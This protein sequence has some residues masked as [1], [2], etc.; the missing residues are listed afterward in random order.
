MSDNSKN[1]FTSSTSIVPQLWFDIPDYESFASQSS[2][3]QCD[4]D[5]ACPGSIDA[6]YYRAQQFQRLLQEIDSGT[7]T[8]IWLNDEVFSRRF[9]EHVVTLSSDGFPIV[10]L[11]HEANRLCSYL[12]E[13]S[14]FRDLR[15]KF[16]TW[17]DF[18]YERTVAFLLSA[19]ILC[20][21]KMPEA[22]IS[23]DQSKTLAVWLHLTSQCNLTCKYCYVT[24]NDQRMD[25]SIAKRSVGAIFR[26]A[27]ANDFR[28]VKLKYGGGEPT[29]NFEAL[30]VA[31]HQ[32]EILSNQ[33]GVELESVLLTNGVFLT[34]NQL[35]TLLNHNVRVTVSLDG[36]GHN[37]DG[38]RPV[39]GRSRDSFEQVSHTLDRLLVR[40]LL[41]HI[42]VTITKENIQGL[43][44]LVEYLLNRQL[45]FSFNFYRESDH[46]NG[47][48]P[49]AFSSGQIIDGLRLTFRAIEK[50]L[51]SYSLLS[52]LANRADMRIPHL[53]TCG[54][55]HNYMVIDCCGK[56]AKCQM[57]MHN[58]VT[59]ISANDPLGV[60][61]TDTSQIQ[62]PLVDEKECRA[63]IWR[64][65][66]LGDCPRLTF[67]RTG[68]YDA[69]SPFCQVYQ[70]ILPEIVNLEAM[71][72]LKYKES[73]D[74]LSFSNRRQ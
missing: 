8:D 26:S 9:A 19:G 67:Q 54:V 42:S 14:T 4:C 47:P 29:L 32:A 25:L 5:G 73:W 57:D 46:L 7:V 27:L 43:P 60:V 44:R 35:D 64:Y 10:V 40:G 55:G 34:D 21:S 38:Q 37:Q 59:T 36:V 50:R 22:R 69:K 31:Q 65:H 70:T 15:V 51:P 74:F 18:E 12:N 6:N 48:D 3:G 30:R 62:N 41:P 20:S 16:P 66:C 23:S 11:N 58:P 2:V 72:L 52:S 56:V 45:H 17:S 28:R 39:I 33:T 1:S 68:R 53:R 71:R 63:C 61:R 49:L 13:Q 24:R